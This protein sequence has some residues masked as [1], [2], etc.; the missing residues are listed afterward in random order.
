MVGPIIRQ[1]NRGGTFY[2]IC[3]IW[4]TQTLNSMRTEGVKRKG[5]K[6]DDS[7]LPNVEEKMREPTPPLPIRLHGVVLK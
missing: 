6:Y 2:Q 5:R 1:I 7:S 4:F 3:V